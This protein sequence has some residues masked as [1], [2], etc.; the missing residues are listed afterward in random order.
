MPRQILDK[1]LG[2]GGAPE[3]GLAHEVVESR[4]GGAERVDALMVAEP[5]VLYGNEGVDQMGGHVLIGDKDLRPSAP[6]GTALGGVKLAR[7]GRAILGGIG[8]EPRGLGGGDL[9]EGH[10]HS[11]R[12]VGGKIYAHGRDGGCYSRQSYRGN[13]YDDPFSASV[14]HGRASFFVAVRFHQYYSTSNA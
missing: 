3:G 8:K 13:R 12:S 9:H 11:D 7:A 5:L 10:V 1:L 6:D 2:D 4:A 14:L